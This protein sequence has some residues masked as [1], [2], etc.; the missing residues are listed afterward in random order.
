MTDLLARGSMGVSPAVGMR[1]HTYLAIT[2]CLRI[3]ASARSQPRLAR[4]LGVSPLTA[5]AREWYRGAIGEL[6]VA[7]LLRALPAGWSMLRSTDPTAEQLLI[8]P[9]GVFT[10]S[11]HDHVGQR[12]TVEHGRVLVNGRRTNHLAN[13]RHEAIRASRLLSTGVG[14]TVDVT[15]VIAIVDP[16][17]LHLDR[18]APLDAIVL[19]SSQLARTLLRRKRR[20]TDAAATALAARV[21]ATGAWHAAAGQLDETL[22]HEARFARL[23]HAVH[24]AILRR[25]AWLLGATGLLVAALVVAIF[26]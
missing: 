14:E 15:P 4:L 26:A 21:E 7:K 20:L 10:I 24:S 22:R 12:V 23:Q 17:S 16:G 5:D 9:A 13:A 25:T 11:I 18:P 3:Q 1:P 2:E 6:H 19:A 8:G